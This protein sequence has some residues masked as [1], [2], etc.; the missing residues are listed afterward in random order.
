MHVWNE[1][2]NLELGF[3]GPTE[4]G[5]QLASRE[6]W[7][8]IIYRITLITV[9]V[10]LELVLPVIAIAAPSFRRCATYSQQYDLL[11]ENDSKIQKKK[12]RKKEI[13]SLQSGCFRSGQ[14]NIYIIFFETKNNV[15]DLA[16]LQQIF[17]A[18][19]LRGF[20]FSYN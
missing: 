11:A 1:W 5:S 15:V 3:Q 6:L 14:F 2:E 20:P 12:E 4:S 9:Q 7:I 18:S 10:E 19:Q 8:V 17:I 13:S 16:R